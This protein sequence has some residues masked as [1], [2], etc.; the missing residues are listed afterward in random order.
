MAYSDGHFDEF[1]AQATQGPLTF[2]TNHN[3]A[4]NDHNK[5]PIYSVWIYFKLVL[6]LFSSCRPTAAIRYSLIWFQ[7]W[8]RVMFCFDKP[9]L[10]PLL[11]YMLKAVC[12]FLVCYY[13]TT[14]RRA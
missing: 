8:V 10:V 9:H 12:S 3:L 1:R 5:I 4:G 11:M 7:G 2:V 13:I 14:S 6:A